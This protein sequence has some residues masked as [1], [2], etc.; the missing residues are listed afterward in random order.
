MN[1]EPESQA[2][3]DVGLFILPNRHA[4]LWELSGAKKRN[5]LP[6]IIDTQKKLRIG[7]LNLPF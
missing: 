6:I 4:F 5:R 1:S 7:I 2:D 3:Q